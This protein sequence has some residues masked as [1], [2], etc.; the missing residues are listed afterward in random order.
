MSCLLLGN[1]GSH[2]SR[3][4]LTLDV[5]HHAFAKI[6]VC[7]PTNQLDPPGSSLLED[8]QDPESDEEKECVGN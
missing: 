8:S 7:P 1:E 2:A 3:C 5:I 6:V 4:D